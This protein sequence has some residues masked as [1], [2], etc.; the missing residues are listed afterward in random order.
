MFATLFTYAPY[1][2][3]ATVFDAISTIIDCFIF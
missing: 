1:N 3:A 2:D